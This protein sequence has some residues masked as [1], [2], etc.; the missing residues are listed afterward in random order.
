MS[1]FEQWLA[2]TTCQHLYCGY[3]DSSILSVTFKV[4]F[5]TKFTQNLTNSFQGL[6]TPRWKEAAAPIL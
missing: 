1:L 2:T 3:Q 5:K 4:V 6:I